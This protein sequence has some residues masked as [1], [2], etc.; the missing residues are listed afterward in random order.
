MK[1]D[2]ALD[3]NHWH[4]AP[5]N[6][7]HASTLIQTYHYAGTAPAVPQYVHGLLSRGREGLV[8]GGVVWWLPPAQAVGPGVCE[9]LSLPQ[10]FAQRVL[11]LSRTVVLP[12]MPKNAASFLIGRS[13]RLIRKDVART[14][15]R[16][17]AALVTFADTWQG[18]TGAIYKATNW[19]YD[20]LT[21]AY[22][23]YIDTKTGKLVG[24]KSGW[25]NYTPQELEQAG[26]RLIGRFAKHRYVKALVN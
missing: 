22:P 4:V 1:P 17:W 19:K 20:G 10:S 8:V 11:S 14:P 26:V 23:V 5:I 12:D 13:I 6:A 21:R 15:W 24:R 3:A 7:L 9:S 25:H 18:H 2:N 16:S